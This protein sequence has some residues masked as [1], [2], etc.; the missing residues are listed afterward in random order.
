MERK[1]EIRHFRDLEVYQKAFK[2][3]MRIYEITKFFPAEEK[4]S[5]VDQIRKSRSVCSNQAEAWRKR[6]LG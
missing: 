5:L 2:A 4:Y 6:K 3:A 1:R